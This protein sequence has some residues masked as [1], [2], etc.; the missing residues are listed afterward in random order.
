VRDYDAEVQ[1]AADSGGW[2]ADA[3][4]S[5]TK[6]L[7]LGKEAATGAAQ[8][9]KTLGEAQQ[10][11]AENMAAD[12]NAHIV[13]EGGLW[14]IKG[15]AEAAAIV[16]RELGDT[17][18][19]AAAKAAEGSADWKRVQDVMIESQKV[20]NDYQIKLGELSNK[21]YEI[22]VKAS[23]DLQTAEIEAETAR[24]GQAFNSLTETIG[25]FTTGATDL[26]GLFEKKAGFTGA[27]Q[28]EEAAK[29]ME[30]RIDKELDLKEQ[31]TRAIVEQAQSMTQRL[32]SG[33][34]LIQ[35]DGGDLSPELEMIFDKILKYTQ[36]RTTQEGLALLLGV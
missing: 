19:T 8:S 12:N 5:V 10:F 9:F 7:G 27:S 21:R 36:T 11:V 17:S 34:A 6:S 3:V 16:T 35:I 24:I 26:W 15:A 18:K 2:F 32:N 28:L 14:K 31:L 33:Q 1:A 22:A 20:A 23:V 29:R 30:Q 4:N 25:T 13:L